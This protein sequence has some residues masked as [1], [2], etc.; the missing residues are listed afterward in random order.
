MSKLLCP[1]Y[2]FL[3]ILPGLEDALLSID[4]QLSFALVGATA[5]G[6]NL[7]ALKCWECPLFSAGQVALSVLG[8]FMAYA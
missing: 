1:S 3:E 4:S 7:K 6:G 5:P 8:T 2:I